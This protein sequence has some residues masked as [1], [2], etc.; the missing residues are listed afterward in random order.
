MT[1]K[2]MLGKK[3]ARNE[4]DC[5]NGG[6]GCDD[7][8]DKSCCPDTMSFSLPKISMP[9]L[10]LGC[11]SSSSHCEIPKP[12]WWHHSA[13]RVTSLACP[14][15][16]AV[17][18]ICVKNTGPVP[19]NFQVEVAPATASANATVMPSAFTLGP[20]EERRVVVT[21]KVPSS[22]PTGCGSNILIWI[23]GCL[24]HYVEWTI[25]TTSKVMQSCHEVCVRDEP[26]YTLEWYHHFYCDHPC[27]QLREKPTYGA[28]Q[29]T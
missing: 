24:N 16:T 25:K 11:G 1:F 2:M 15:G 19:R 21:Y 12:F 14:E 22:H 27:Q 4:E 13:G 23:R 18:Q 8:T 3:P 26:V 28:T 7:S 10:R 29:S 6:S 20:M 9:N 17:V 5:S